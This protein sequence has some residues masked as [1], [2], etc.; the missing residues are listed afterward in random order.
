MDLAAK[1]NV[2]FEATTI[3]W[4]VGVAPNKLEST[5]ALTGIKLEGGNINQGLLVDGYE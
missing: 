3:A 1:L 4:S 5:Y 2:D